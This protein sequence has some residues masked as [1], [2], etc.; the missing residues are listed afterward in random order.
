MPP[1]Q[2]DAFV[3]FGAT[4][5]LAYKKIFPALQA[6]IRTRARRP[7]IGISRA[8]GHSRSCERVRA[9]RCRTMAAST[10]VRLQSLPHCCG[11]RWRLR[12]ACHYERLRMRLAAPSAAA[13]PGDSSKHVRPRRAGAGAPGLRDRCARDRR[14]PFGRD[15]FASAR[16]D[17]ALH[18]VFPESSVFRNRFTISAKRRCRTC[19]TSDSPCGSWT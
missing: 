6:M 9:I 14:E 11:S 16:A 5:D 18:E 4:G 12:R 15:L 13:L 10:W 19:C 2:S 17:R 7:I 1:P 8:A 3:L